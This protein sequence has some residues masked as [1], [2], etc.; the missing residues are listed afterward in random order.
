MYEEMFFLAIIDFF[1]KFWF[2]SL[3]FRWL[4]GFLPGKLSEMIRFIGNTVRFP[5]KRFFYWL[6][7]VKVLET[8][9]EKSL[10][11][12]EK[13]RDFDCRITS[14]IAGPLL[15]LTYV[16]SIAF[17]WAHYLYNTGYKWLGITLYVFGFAV[18]LM[19]APDKNEVEELV[20]VSV[21]SVFKWV[22]KVAILSVPAYL[23][24][25]FLVGI[26]TLAQGAFV[27][28]LLVPFY[29]HSHNP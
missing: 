29:F 8:D 21:K 6:Y 10:F 1:I 25:H 24:I 13:V 2:F 4:I 20:H 18:I 3:F 14:N 16:S 28:G 9:L 23:L 26:E 22:L 27:L 19:A 15:I 11:K 17:Y 12:T 7:G 5:V